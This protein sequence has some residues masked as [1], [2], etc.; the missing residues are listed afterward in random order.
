[1]DLASAKARIGDRVTIVGNVDATGVMCQPNKQLIRDA[2]AE[3][4][5]TAGQDGALIIATDHSFHEGIPAENV[6]YFLGQ[7]KQLGKFN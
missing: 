1:M 2:I 3:V 4:V 6:V 7:A 5:K